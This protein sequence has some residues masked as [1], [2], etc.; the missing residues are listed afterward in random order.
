[1]AVV[2]NLHP[3]AARSGAQ[4]RRKP[5]RARCRN[6]NQER[7][8]RLYAAQRRRFDLGRAL[9]RPPRVGA[10][11]ARAAVRARERQGLSASDVLPDARGSEAPVTTSATPPLFEYVLRFADSDLVLAQRLGEWVGRGPVLEEDI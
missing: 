9:R 4:A 5:A 11:R 8:R 6:G 10:E 7:P 1:M 2:G 3:L